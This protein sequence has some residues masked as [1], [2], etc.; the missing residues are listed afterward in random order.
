MLLATSTDEWD[1]SIWGP[2]I[3]SYRTCTGKPI[4]SD[5]FVLC[6]IV[7]CFEVE[8]KIL[9]FFMSKNQGFV[10]NQIKTFCYDG[11]KGQNGSCESGIASLIVNKLL[12]YFSIKGDGIFREDHIIWSINFQQ[13]QGSLQKRPFTLVFIQSCKRLHQS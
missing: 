11:P 4:L 10:V 2:C 9:Y 5:F 6:F 1:G 8:S 12:I 3:A 13:N 7:N